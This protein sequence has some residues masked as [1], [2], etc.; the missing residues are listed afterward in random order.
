MKYRV[1]FFMAAFLAA[2]IIGC[3]KQS[4]DDATKTHR[5]NIYDESANGD[6][7]VAD[8]VV[9]AEREHKRILLQ[10]GAN[11]CEWCLRLHKLFESDKSVS[12]ELRADYIVVLIDVNNEHNKDLVVKYGAET[13]Y[14]LPFL[15]VLDSDGAHLITKHSDDFEEGD[16][17]SPQKVLAFLKAPLTP[18]G[19]DLHSPIEQTNSSSQIAMTLL[20]M[21]H[22]W[23][24]NDYRAKGMKLPPMLDNRNVHSYGV[25]L[26]GAGV[27]Y[28][29]QKDGIEWS[30]NLGIIRADTNSTTWTLYERA[31]PTDTN[32][33]QMAWKH[34]LIT[35]KGEP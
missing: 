15:V 30:R 12:E 33:F 35:V 14:G 18:S 24:T 26:Y 20:E 21:H 4:P 29:E 5:T 17:H 25:G 9:I 7:Q 34:N 22:Q 19:P 27:E 2:T 28:Y 6:R 13:G 8:A 11:W 31:T 10:F 16:H 1:L 23:A 32:L 3:S